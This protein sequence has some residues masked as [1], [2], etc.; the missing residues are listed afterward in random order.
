MKTPNRTHYTDKFSRIAKVFGQH[1]IRF[2]QA[3]S[4]CISG[5]EKKGKDIFNIENEDFEKELLDIL[6]EMDKK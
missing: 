2:G 4:I 5:L 1:D 3:I 6:T